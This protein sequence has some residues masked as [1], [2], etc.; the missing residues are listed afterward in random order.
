MEELAFKSFEASVRRGFN[1]MGLAAA[2]R[3]TSEMYEPEFRAYMDR[4]LGALD[5]TSWAGR[6]RDA[7]VAA[8][9]D[10][11]QRRIGAD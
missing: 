11:S 6:G 5:H 8:V 4:T 3:L 1:A 2:W 7:W 9:S 10:L